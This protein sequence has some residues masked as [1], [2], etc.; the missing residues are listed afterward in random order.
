MNKKQ[1]EAHDKALSNSLARK[2]Q[3]VEF[4]PI[5]D[6]G[7]KWGFQAA[8]S[9]HQKRLGAYAAYINGSI[10]RS[11]LDKVLSDDLSASS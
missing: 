8:I 1:W 2:A 9:Y 7:F 11:E 3:P 4:I 10:T 6:D 5:F